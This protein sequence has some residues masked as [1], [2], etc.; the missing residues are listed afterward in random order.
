M[1]LALELGAR[2]EDHFKN[3]QSSTETRAHWEPFAVKKPSISSVPQVA[4][5]WQNGFTVSRAGGPGS[6]LNSTQ[7][8]LNAELNIAPAP[9]PLRAPTVGRRARPPTRYN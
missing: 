6:P 3:K 1:T 8:A 5:V 2:T 4:V 7:Y 9:G